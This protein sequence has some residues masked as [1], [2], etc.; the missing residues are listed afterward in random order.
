MR[1]QK[2][3]TP[4]MRGILIDWLV[5]VSEETN[6]TSDVL[7][8]AKNYLDRFMAV[9]PL[10]R[11]EVQLAGTTAILIAAYAK[12]HLF[13]SFVRSQKLTFFFFFFFFHFDPTKQ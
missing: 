13:K 11:G 3:V 2:E 4:Q 12:K 5:E 10:L 8:L 7:Y 9:E 1:K 6:L